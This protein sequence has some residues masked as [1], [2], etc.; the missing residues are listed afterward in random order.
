MQQQAGGPRCCHKDPRRCRQ[1]VRARLKMQQQASSF[2]VVQSSSSQFPT[3]SFEEE[4]ED[5]PLHRVYIFDPESPEEVE[6][7]HLEPHPEL[8]R[9]HDLLA[10]QQEQEAAGTV[11]DIWGLARQQAGDEQAAMSIRES[12]AAEMQ[13]ALVEQLN[14]EQQQVMEL[15]RYEGLYKEVMMRA[16]RSE[17]DIAY[18]QNMVAEKD[19]ELAHTYKLLEASAAERSRLRMEHQ[20]AQARMRE[21]QAQLIQAQAQAR[22]PK[23]QAL[24]A[25]SP[26]PPPAASPSSLDGAV[27]ELTNLAYSLA[28]DM[29]EDIRNMYPSSLPSAQAADS[30]ASTP[31]SHSSHFLGHDVSSQPTPSW[32]NSEGSDSGFAHTRQWP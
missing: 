9:A 8:D 20:A 13:K 7:S 23:A 15:Q 19:A 28:M 32:L 25:A 31:P 30:P 12:K 5:Q 17:A 27:E 14:M 11:P 24:A 18:M 16:D 26:M 10:Q 3:A 6:E 2:A 4:G 21:L 1:Q 22:A 29:S